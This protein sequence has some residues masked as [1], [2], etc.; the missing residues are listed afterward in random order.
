[1]TDSQRWFVLCVLLISI[2]LVYLLEP[3]LFP[4]LASFLLAYLWDPVADKLEAQGCSR[5][6]SVLIVFS[7]F[8]LFLVV[9]VLL[10]VPMLGRQIEALGERVPLFLERL[11]TVI[12]PWIETNLGFDP[13]AIDLEKVRAVFQDHWR[14]SGSIV[15]QVVAKASQ[16]GLVL[17]G[18]VANLLLIPVVTFYL[19]RDWDLMIERINNLLPRNMEH[20]ISRWAKECDEVLGAFLKGQLLVMLSLAVI[21]SI[22]LTLIGLDLALLIGML[23]GLASVVPY[24]GFIVGIGAAAI[25]SFMQFQDV[26]HLILVAGVFGVGQAL[27]GT[28]LTP[29]LVGDKIGLHPVAVIF[30]IMAG[31]QLFGFTGILLALPVAAVVMVLLRHLHEGYL[32]SGIYTAGNNQ[33]VK[34]DKND[35]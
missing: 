23:A 22:G 17:L 25:A 33:P 2:G 26:F 27:E 20:R 19:L 21:Y 14:E 12:L 16:S 35:S 3:I 28:V 5:T 34:T 6:T 24:M 30:A 29:L 32:I 18:L 8:S 4:F 13:R 31:G 11:D 9:L 10:L 15:T 1:M 7:L